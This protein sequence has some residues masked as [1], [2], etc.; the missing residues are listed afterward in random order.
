[1]LRG[2]QHSSLANA[3]VFSVYFSGGEKR[4]SEIRLRSQATN[5]AEVT[6][7]ERLYK[8]SYPFH[9][10]NLFCDILFSRC[11]QPGFCQ[12]IHLSFLYL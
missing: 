5:V 7:C 2:H 3:D 12:Q 1:M 4:R 6:S 11:L 8:V 9:N 10:N